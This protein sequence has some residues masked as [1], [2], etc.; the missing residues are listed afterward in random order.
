MAD[1][2]N[3]VTYKKLAK[4]KNEEYDC[5]YWK[6]IKVLYEGQSAWRKLCSTDKKLM[7]ELLPKNAGEEDYVYKE[8]CRGA[9][10]V[11]VLAK[12]VDYICASLSGDPV[13]V[14]EEKN[15]DTDPA[16]SGL[17]DGD[18][19]EQIDPFY[20]AFYLDCSPPGGEK[21][22]IQQLLAE[23]V[24]IALL[25][26]RAWT[27]IDFPSAEAQPANLY[28]E[29]QLGLRNA[30][31]C[32]VEPENVL[33]WEVDET[34]EL[35]WVLMVNITRKRES[36]LDERNKIRE[37]YSLYDRENWYR[38]V[39]EYI[40]GKNEPKDNDPPM[41]TESGKH[42]FG[43]VPFV[44]LELP[45]G[46]WAGGKLEGIATEHFNKLNAA[47][48]TMKR[49]L[50]P[51]LIAKLQNPDPKDGLVP[52]IEDTNR[53]INQTIGPGRMMTMAERDSIEYISPPT[54]IFKIAYDHMQD[55]E[56]KMHAVVHQMAMSI[57]NKGAALRRSGESKQID[58]S[59][60]AVILSELGRRGRDFIEDIYEMVSRGRG[61]GLMFK[62]AGL[63]QFDT[64]TMDT[65]VNEAA[66]VETISIPSPTFQSLYKYEIVRRALPGATEDQLKLIRIELSKSITME[67]ELDKANKLSQGGDNANATDGADGADAK[68]AADVRPAGKGSA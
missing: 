44:C 30:Y 42:S 32:I 11:P 45:S 2:K 67:D 19:D 27:L 16:E 58:A 3:T 50:F 56:D 28:E 8:R 4:I 10:I 55:L 68:D 35:L 21:V 29:E 13:R 34:G 54:D 38:Y 59:S 17:E 47:A 25:F 22:S 43:R 26:K 57:D 12:I 6:K 7:Q 33:D 15:L 49:T 9:Y 18:A 62:A 61:D 23:Q 20:Q 52:I 48:W 5:Q 64:I 51:F 60:T 39:Y 37:E 31:A 46:L 63:D 36:V 24:L 53:A 65:L 14:M 40:P 66:I 41:E 1:D